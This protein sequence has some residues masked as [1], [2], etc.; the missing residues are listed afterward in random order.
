MHQ[1]TSSLNIQTNKQTANTHH[2]IKKSALQIQRA[3]ALSVQCPKVSQTEYKYPNP[4]SQIH[5]ACIHL[6]PQIT[7]THHQIQDNCSTKTW[8][9]YSPPLLAGRS[10]P[11]AYFSCPRSARTDK[12]YKVFKQTFQRKLATRLDTLFEHIQE[13]TF[14][15]L[16]FENWKSDVSKSIHKFT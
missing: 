9:T 14:G 2:Q 1:L 6:I 3:P 13:P 8:S 16:T 4:K 12:V 10:S 5:G 7:N 11:Q 15:H